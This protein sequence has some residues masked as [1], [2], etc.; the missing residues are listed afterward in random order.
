[1]ATKLLIKGFD[2]FDEI[3]TGFAKTASSLRNRREWRSFYAF[4]FRAMVDNFRRNFTKLPPNATSTREWKERMRRKGTRVP[5]GGFGKRP[6]RFTVVGKR[7]G[8][9]FRSLASMRRQA[10]NIWQTDLHGKPGNWVY[11][12][13]T[14]KASVASSEGKGLPYAKFFNN[15]Y[16]IFALTEFVER[17]IE[18]EMNRFINTRIVKYLFKF[19]RS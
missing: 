19:Y 1:M 4:V 18:M 17:R 11:G 7:T 14:S 10:A 3:Q 2:I 12:V 6:V 9:L 5:T 15:R 13:A 16:N 8:Y